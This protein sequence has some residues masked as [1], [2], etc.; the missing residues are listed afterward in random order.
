MSILFFMSYIFL[1]ISFLCVKKTN[2][3]LNIILWIFISVILY[4]GYNCM[5]VYLL[6]FF[7]IKS[8]LLLRSIINIVISLIINFVSKSKQKYYIDK[9]DIVMVLILLYLS[10]V[11]FMVRFGFDFCIN[12]RVN[13]A[14][15]HYAMAKA[16]MS[17]NIYNHSMHNILYNIS[18]RGMFFS[19]INAGTFME[20][21]KPLTGSFYLYKSFIIFEVL[22]FFIGGV[23]FYFIVKKSNRFDKKY[24]LTVLLVI[25]YELGYPLLN[26]LYG[27]HYWG[28]VILV[29]STIILTVKELDSNKMYK[30]K[31]I[32]F[33]LFIQTFSVFVTYYLYVPV[34][35]GALGLYFIFLY[36]WKKKISL[37]E[38]IIYIVFVL[39]IPFIFGL[40]HFGLIEEYILNFGSKNSMSLKGSNYKNL[41]GNFI[42]LFPLLF[43]VIVDEFK[44]RKISFITIITCLN[45]IYMIVLF[46]LC[47]SK[48]MSNYY[49]NKI[50]NLFWLVSFIYLVS[51]VYHYKEKFMKIYIYSYI[52]I[53]VLA[54]FRIEMI[55]KKYNYGI[56]ENTVISNIG[57]VY[58][59][60]F[61]ML[62]RRTVLIDKNNIE[63]LRYVKNHV[64]EYKNS[65]GEIPFIANYFKKIWVTQLL[66]VIVSNNH[67][68]EVKKVSKDTYLK[69]SI[70]EVMTDETVQYFAWIPDRVNIRDID[71]RNFI[72]IYKCKGGYVLRKK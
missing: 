14:A 22:S 11:I 53:S 4:M 71:K 2:N 72:V 68:K 36:K 66:D 1:I 9:T 49:Y 25:L 39:F 28:L 50:Y 43:Y 42:F 27:F 8:S 40:F 61:E 12:F 7:K 67:Q 23:L 21:L 44:S 69:N 57:N 59:A 19:S 13:D 51:T 6:S 15:V 62:Q 38:C 56:S 41:L 16:F 58:D 46:V 60:N 32:L 29:I 63:L 26:L 34:V 17:N 5:F 35:Y 33:I 70:D 54:C 52:I 65:R 31:L 3:K 55:I 47:M 30:N 37:K 18:S 48:I 45:V 64:Q 24:I 20:L 10:F